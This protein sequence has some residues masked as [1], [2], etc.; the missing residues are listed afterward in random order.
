M[1]NRLLENRWKS[2][3]SAGGFSVN[4]PHINAMHYSMA[5]VAITDGKH[6]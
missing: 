5:R 2:D 1:T 6:L 4:K 3:N